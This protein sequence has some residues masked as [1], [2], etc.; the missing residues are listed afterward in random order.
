MSLFRRKGTKSAK[1]IQKLK[2]GFRDVYLECN[3]ALIDTF[4]QAG[5]KEDDLENNMDI[6]NGLVILHSTIILISQ[7]TI[8]DREKSKLAK[9]L[10]QYFEEII[11]KEFSIS[12]R[13]LR[14]DVVKAHDAYM[15]ILIDSTNDTSK[16]NAHIP[17]ILAAVKTNKALA[18]FYEKTG[19]IN[20]MLLLPATEQGMLQYYKTYWASQL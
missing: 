10:L 19:Q 8:R 2:H 1:E 6:Q 14:T 4:K 11:V 15:R 18:D 7:S 16:A 20:L 3:Q 12:I 17:P 13:Q 5:L 9:A